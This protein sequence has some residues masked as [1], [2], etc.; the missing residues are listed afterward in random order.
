MPC[1][2]LQRKVLN[3]SINADV[4]PWGVMR[5][6]LQNDAFQIKKPKLVIWEIPERALSQR[7]SY[8][9]RQERFRMDDAEWLQQ[10]AAWGQGSCEPAPIAARIE[11]LGLGAGQRADSSTQDADFIE[12]GF[13]KP[14]AQ[15]AYLSA[16]V[17][18]NGSRQLRMEAF[19]RSGAVRKFTVEVAGDDVEHA[20][21]IPLSLNAN[22]V[23]RLRI[24]PGQTKAFAL[25]QPQLCRYLE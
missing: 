25:A 16:K 14:V 1:V 11:P 15:Q 10:V 24:Y 19:E 2:S 17:M 22:G 23:S 18:V 9:F 21:K 7:P 3:F 8:Q 13:D 20:L 5:S 12:L 6:Y 4:G